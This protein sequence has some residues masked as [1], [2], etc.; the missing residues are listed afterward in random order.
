MRDCAS[1]L[2]EGLTD[3][4]APYL[5]IDVA[6]DRPPLWAR[7]LDRLEATLRKK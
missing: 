6:A 7:L 1:V 5:K 3:V 4:F 2:Q